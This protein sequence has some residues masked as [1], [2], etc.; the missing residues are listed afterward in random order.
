MRE[1]KYDLAK[2]MYPGFAIECEKC[3]GTEIIIKNTLGFSSESGSW[4]SVKLVCTECGTSTTI[5]GFD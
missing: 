5:V 1:V 2:N 4:G 3:G